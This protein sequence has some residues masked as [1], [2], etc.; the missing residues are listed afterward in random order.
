MQAEH[1]Q[2]VLFESGAEG[3][4]TATSGADESAGPMRWSDLVEGWP[5][6]VIASV[7]VALAV[8]IALAVHHVLFAVLRRVARRTTNELDESLVTALGRP[9]Q[10]LLPIVAALGVLRAQHFSDGLRGLE[11]VQVGLVHTAVL[12]VIATLTWTLTRLVRFGVGVMLRRY[13]VSVSDNLQARRVHTQIGVITRIVNAV[14]WIIGVSIGLMTFESIRHLGTSI[15]ASAG[16]AGLIVGLAAQRTIGNFLAG[17][18]IALTQPICLDDVVVIEGEWGR[19]EEIT[20]TYVVVKIWD[21]RRLIVPFSTIIE[22]PFTNWTRR[23]S[24][25]LGTAFIYVDYT[26]PV[27]AVRQELLAFVAQHEKWDRRVC[28]LQVTDLRERTVELRALVSAADAGKAFDLRCAVRE[29]MIGFL[30]RQFPGSLPRV[31]IDAPEGAS[32]EAG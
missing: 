12:G 9:M 3:V 1:E 15:L 22:R 19:V 20:S 18:Q 8:M 21:D 5:Q 2:A 14:I 27:E 24:Q 10:W 16:L 26:V 11:N 32:S 13:D 28:G 4:R 29:H 6:V 31:R 7:S 17:L 25:I 30:S 23:N